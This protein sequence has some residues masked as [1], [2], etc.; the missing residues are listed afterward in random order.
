LALVAVLLLLGLRT[1]AAVKGI[2]LADVEIRASSPGSVLERP[3]TLFLRFGWAICAMIFWIGFAGLV[4]S[5]TLA[6]CAVRRRDARSALVGA[7]AAGACA[8]CAVL[9]VH[10]GCRVVGV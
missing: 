2:D 3:N 4:Y 10:L 7:S 9:A 1:F 5:V 6:V 8:V